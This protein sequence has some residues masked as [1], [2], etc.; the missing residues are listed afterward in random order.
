[1]I[2]PARKTAALCLA[3]NLLNIAENARSDAEFD[4]ALMHAHET[5]ALDIEAIR[6]RE[7]RPT[8]TVVDGGGA[9]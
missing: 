1:M 3:W 8:F 6:Q 5:F 4:S 2:D 9:A 7:R